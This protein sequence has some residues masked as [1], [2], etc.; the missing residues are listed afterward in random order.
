V[1]AVQKGAAR[2]L[3]STGFPLGMFRDAS[4]ASAC[5]NL[6]AGDLLF[7]Y[8]DGLSEAQGDD[9]EYG[10]ERLTSL[11]SQQTAICA[12]SVIASCIED[13][14][15]FAGVNPGMDDVTLLAMLHEA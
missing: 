15:C 6:S 9:G 12:A 3:E 10:I 11:L 1:I 14:R 8:T 13:L 2:L 4:I 5:L 7:L